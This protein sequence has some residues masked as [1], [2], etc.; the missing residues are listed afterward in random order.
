MI[1]LGEVYYRI[2]RL[3]GEK[4]A[5][6]ILKIIQIAPI[7][8]I[9]VADNLVIKSASLKG[10]FNISYADAFAAATALEK[11]AILLTGDPDFKEMDKRNI[12][13]IEWLERD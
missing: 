4:K 2:F 6:S 7:K 8:T 13:K 11:D 10:R 1:N 9:S 12:L 3:W 5:L